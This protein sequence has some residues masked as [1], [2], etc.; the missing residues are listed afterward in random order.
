MKI[1][2]A[3]LSQARNRIKSAC[4]GGFVEAKHLGGS[5]WLVKALFHSP[6]LMADCIERELEC[7]IELDWND[8]GSLWKASGA[9]R[10]GFGYS[11]V[12]FQAPSK[13]MDGVFVPDDPVLKPANDYVYFIGS[14]R[15]VKIG[16]SR[17]PLERIRSLQT[18]HVETLALLLVI[19]NGERE[20]EFHQRFSHL[21]ARG[22]WFE[23]GDDLMRFI[24]EEKARSAG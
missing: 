2:H 17:E 14:E 23:R 6:F 5:V 3:K 22:E 24:E 11:Y 15:L 20:R 9:W 19:P 16:R 12:R 10:G 13:L 21:R 18:G 4:P 1:D 8:S 7:D